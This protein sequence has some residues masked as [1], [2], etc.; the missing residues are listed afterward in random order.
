MNASSNS[1]VVAD[2]TGLS[3]Q[4]KRSKSEVMKDLKN[5]KKVESLLVEAMNQIKKK[6]GFNI[7]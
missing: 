4:N 6:L 7:L 2:R 1:N 5:E 3:I